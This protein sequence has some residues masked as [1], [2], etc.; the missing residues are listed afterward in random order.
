MKFFVFLM[1]LLSFYCKM[2]KTAFAI[3]TIQ[4]VKYFAS[5]RASETNVRSGPGHQYPVKFAF[6][7][8]N[9]P[10]L[11]VSE[12]DNWLEI[13]DYQNEKGWVSQSLITKKR[14]LM[15]INATQNVAMYK[16]NNHNSKILFMLENFVIGEYQKCQET[17]CLISINNK[18]GWVKK[19]NLYGFD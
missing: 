8:K 7:N 1:F 6:Q 12:Y 15:V 16:K 11:V 17:M 19:E 3:A 9:I 18:E 5:L 13:Q 2:A 10:V 14:H 4:E